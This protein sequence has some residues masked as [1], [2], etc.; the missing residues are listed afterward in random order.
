METGR[1]TRLRRILRRKRIKRAIKTY[2]NYIAAGV[3]VF[4]VCVAVV[5]AAV[6][7]T[8]STLPKNTPEPVQTTQQTG[9]TT[10]EAEAYPFNLMSFD[11]DG[12]ALDGWTRYEV[13][14][15]YADNGGYFP[16]CMQQFTYIIC[17][18]N[19]VDYALVLAIIETES[20]YRWDATSSEG[21][22]GYMQVLAKWHE[23]RMHRL[24]V[25]NV[26]NPYFNIMVGVDY[27]AEL[28]ERFD[29][30]AEV[31]TAYNYG[32]TGAYQH[33]WNKGLTDTEYSREVQQ[34][35]ERIERRMRGEW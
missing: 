9:S 25:D 5:G 23:E 34:A 19:G 20:G 14:E 28:Q 33:V 1:K 7:P 32:V 2:G 29:T 21:S 8:A 4:V 10:E 18:Q 12:E 15:D 6:K 22:T 24:N 11:W 27:L 13:P 3:L 30:E 17:K 31:L 16:E 26:E 35:K